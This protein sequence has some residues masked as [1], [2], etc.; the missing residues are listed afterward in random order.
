MRVSDRIKCC[1]LASRN[2]IELKMLAIQ[3]VLTSAVTVKC[4]VLHGG[5]RC[6]VSGTNN[7][8]TEGRYELWRNCLGGGGDK[9][10]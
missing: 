5:G 1:V 8:R 7:G 2:I 10:H 6:V 9:S 4:Y 3:R